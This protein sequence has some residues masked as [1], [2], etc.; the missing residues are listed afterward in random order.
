MMGASITTDLRYGLP[1]KGIPH[2]RDGCNER[3]TVGHT[4]QCSR[5][6]LIMQRHN[7]IL[8]ELLELCKQADL[9]FVTMPMMPQQSKSF[10]EMSPL[11]AFGE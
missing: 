7:D 4:I 5:G 2:R 10:K 3:F 8:M 11:E 1:P 6:G 9:H